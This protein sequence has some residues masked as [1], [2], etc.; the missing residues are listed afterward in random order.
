MTKN[1]KPTWMTKEILNTMKIGVKHLRNVV[2]K[3]FLEM[4]L[5]KSLTTPEIESL[6]SKIVGDHRNKESIVREEGKRIMKTRIRLKRK[7][8]TSQKF[9]WT[10][11]SRKLSNML[12]LS[13]AENHR[14]RMITK[15]ELREHWHKNRVK[16][17]SKVDWL[18]QKQKPTSNDIPKEYRGILI[19]DKELQDKF[20]DTEITVAVYSGIKPSENV[21]EF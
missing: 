8:I 15:A 17:K 13:P 9:E 11:K 5:K 19:G 3:D 14:M 20:G 16:L 10:S 1:Q 18:Q 4:C 2:K 12:K 21:V 6:A 7:D